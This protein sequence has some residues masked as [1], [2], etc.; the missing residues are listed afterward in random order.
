MATINIDD[1]DLAEV[2][3]MLQAAGI[4]YSTDED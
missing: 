2:E 4:M 1:S 3:E